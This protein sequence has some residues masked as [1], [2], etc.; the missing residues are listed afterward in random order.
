MSSI[1]KYGFLLI[2]CLCALVVHAQKI[3]DVTNPDSFQTYF[4]A[5]SRMNLITSGIS[6]NATN[7]ALNDEIEAT[8][9]YFEGE[10]YEKGI[11]VEICGRLSS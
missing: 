3:E 5:A 9:A 8:A 1:T 2:L 11:I 7:G 6:G 10:I 4:S